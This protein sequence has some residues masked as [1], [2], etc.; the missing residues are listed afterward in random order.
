MLDIKEQDFQNY[1]LLINPFINNE[2]VIR[3]ENKYDYV[4][5]TSLRK[6][7]IFNMINNYIIL[8]KIYN[9]IP[10]EDKKY[11]TIEKLLNITININECKIQLIFNN[12]GKGTIERIKTETEINNG[13]IID[14]LKCIYLLNN[15]G[16]IHF[17][18]KQDN[19]ILHENKLQLIDHGMSCKKDGLFERII[20]ML[21]S[22]NGIATLYPLEVAF[23]NSIYFSI[24]K[25]IE[26]NPG[27]SIID[28]TIINKKYF[29]DNETLIKEKL[30]FI[31]FNGYCG[32]FNIL[33]KKVYNTGDTFVDKYNVFGM[34]DTK[35]TQYN[36]NTAIDLIIDNI[37]NTSFEIFIKDK[38]MTFKDLLSNI[39]DYH[40]KIDTFYVGLLLL[41]INKGK[42]DTIIEK[43]LTLDINERYTTE[44]LHVAFNTE[45][46]EQKG[47]LTDISSLKSSSLKPLKPLKPLSKDKIISK[48]KMIKE[49]IKYDQNYFNNDFSKNN[50]IYAEGTDETKNSN[51]NNIIKNLLDYTTS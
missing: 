45:F 2:L 11:L 13:H 16:F 40:K 34:K 29:Q 32:V 23:I 6:K 30:E 42:Y 8:N 35:N 9:D 39:K 20:S 18:I 36:K 22:T 21:N 48:D 47:G 26:N 12:F 37:Y 43:C 41:F 10:T 31:M 25:N 49:F 51:T 15:N 5:K 33:Y 24:K 4:G 50:Y 7:A 27:K 14:L 44:E 3:D 19:I 38:S 46:S 1:V 28:E 17:D